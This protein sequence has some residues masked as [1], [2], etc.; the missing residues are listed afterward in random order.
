MEYKFI[1][2]IGLKTQ[3]SYLHGVGNYDTICRSGV[4]EY[5]GVD[6]FILRVDNYGVLLIKET[7]YWVFEENDFT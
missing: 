5:V 4:I 6:Y 7:E 1:P 3:D 2:R